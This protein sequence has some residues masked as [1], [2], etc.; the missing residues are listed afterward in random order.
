MLP[1][2]ASKLGRKK[3][4]SVSLMAGAVGLISI[5]FISNQYVLI[6][7]MVG[8]GIAW[9]SIL[10]MPYAILAGSIPA[11]KMGIYMGIFNFFITFPQI[12]N[13]VFGGLIVKY[14][15]DDQAVLALVTSGVFLLIGAIAVLYVEDKDD[16]I[17]T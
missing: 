9:A 16:I 4:H 5:Y 8:V 3:T 12:V 11:K 1:T 2:I 10:A 6:L 7:S 15:Y 13:G 17:A 14:L